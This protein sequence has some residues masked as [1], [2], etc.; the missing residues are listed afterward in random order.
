MRWYSSI[1]TTRGWS[2]EQSREAEEWS[3]RAGQRCGV[4]EAK[5]ERLSALRALYRHVGRWAAASAAVGT[6]GGNSGGGHG[7][8]TG[9]AVCVPCFGH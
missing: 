9:R 2:G 1:A 4:E 8:S 5:G 3:E 7:L 6:M